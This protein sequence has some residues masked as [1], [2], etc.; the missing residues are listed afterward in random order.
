MVAP[1]VKAKKPALRCAMGAGAAVAASYAGW[2]TLLIRRGF[3]ED[4]KYFF[5]I[6][7]YPRPAGIWWP[8]VSLW[9][10]FHGGLWI[11]K[12]LIP[13]AGFLV[14][15]AL[16][17]L[18]SRRGLLP[19][20]FLDPVFGAS[21]LAVAGYILFMTYQDHPQPR[22]FAVVAFFCFFL[23]AQATAALVARAAE[24]GSWRAAGWVTVAFIAA[25]ACVNGA[26]TLDYATHPQYTWVNAAAGLTRYIDMHPNGNRILLS[27]SGDE[28][29]L[30][31]RLPGLCDDFGT[32]E[33]PDKIEKYKPGW[34][35]SWNDLDP[36]TLADLHT[37]YSL[38][39]AAS[40]PAFDDKQRNLLILFKLRPLPGGQ[41]RDE[42]DMDLRVELP[43]DSF[44]APIQ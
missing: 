39:E 6:N 42:G 27:V 31:T 3:L 9:W 10:S 32:M 2:M 37:H 22:Y 20:L 18:R 5:F 25:T 11:D 14:L 17:F 21:L 19:N 28:I 43:D 8:F 33:L 29:T 13:L 34:F 35:A 24:S 30:L 38:E 23:I 15:G 41:V 36:G 26:R 7:Q 40:F 12:I 1:L 44:D 4:Y 16:V